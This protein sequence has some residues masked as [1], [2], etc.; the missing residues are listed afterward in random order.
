MYVAH[1]VIVLVQRKRLVERLSDK[2]LVRGCLRVPVKV[3]HG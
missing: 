3:R 2:V 1:L